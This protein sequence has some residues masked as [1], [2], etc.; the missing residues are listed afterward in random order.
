MSASFWTN[1]KFELTSRKKFISSYLYFAL[2]ATLAYLLV[3]GMGGAM[4][5]VNVSFGL[6]Q[7]VLVNSP[8]AI[9]LL[10]S[11]MSLFGVL[12]ISPVFGRSV[13]KDYDAK[14]DQIVFATPAH[15]TGFYLGRFVGATVFCL[16]AFFGLVVGYYLGSVSPWVQKSLFTANRLSFYLWP[17]FVSVL[18]NIMIFGSLAFAVAAFTKRM[19][20]V[21][22]TGILSFM[23]YIFAGSF[24]GD[25]EKKTLASLV[26]PF[27]INAIS[28]LTEYWSVAERNSRLIPIQGIFLANR[29]LWLGVALTL[30]AAA[31]Y[32][33]QRRSPKAKQKAETLKAPDESRAPMPE[34]KSIQAAARA[35]LD[36]SPRA[37]FSLFLSQLKFETKSA[38]KNIYFVCLTFAGILYVFIAAGQHGLIYGTETY[39]VTYSMLELIAGSFNIFFII[40]ILFYTGELIW[41]DRQSRMNQLIDAM[42]TP[43]WLSSAAKFGAMQVLI[44]CTLAILAVCNMLVQASKG[45][46]HFELGQVFQTLYLQEY[47]SLFALSGLAFFI[48]TL[49]NNKYLG[50]GVFVLYL[51]AKIVMSN[52]GFDHQLYQIASVPTAKYSDM[53]GFGPFLGRVHALQLYW[54]FGVGLMLTAVYLFWVRGTETAGRERWALAKERFTPRARTVAALLFLGFLLQGGYIF[55]NTNVLNEYHMEK[56]EERRSAEYEKTYKAKWDEAPSLKVTAVK[57]QVD[58]FPS[59]LWLKARMVYTLENKTGAPVSDIFLNLPLHKKYFTF[60]FDH[61]AKL[62]TDDDVHDVQIYTFAKPVEP[63]EKVIFT[64]DTD[65]GYEGFRNSGNPTAIAGN[66]SFF[67]S[68]AYFP[69]IGYS[70]SGELS[71]D[72]T[73]E[74][75]GLK[76]KT[77]NMPEI[78]NEKERQYTYVTGPEGDWIDFEATVSTDPDQIAIAPGYLQKEWREGGRRYFEY[79]MDRK[80][81]NFFAFLSARYEVKRDTFNGINLEIYYNKGHEYDLDTMLA[82]T[83]AGLAYYSETFGPY[84]HKQFRIIE[85]PRYASFAQSFPNTIPFSEAIGFIAK[86]DPKNP[87]DLDY[88]YQVTAHELAHQWWAHQVIGANVQGSTMLVE[89]LAEYSSLLLM[90]KKFGREKMS[91]YLDYERDHYLTGRSSEDKAEEP[92]ALNDGQP[93]LHYNKGALVM[94]ALKEYIGEKELNAAIRKYAD[95]VRYQ[96]PPFTTSLELVDSLKRDLDPKYRGLIDDMLMKITLYDNRILSADVKEENGTFNVRLEV[97]GKKMY[98]S[99]KGEETEAPLDL[100]VPVVL[101]DEQGK[102]LA[103]THYPLKSADNSI[104]ISSKVKPYKVKLDPLGVLID[105]NRDDNQKKL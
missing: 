73:R 86:V 6:S 92:L 12:V 17:F 29:A 1:L 99:E 71:S 53:N 19:S 2:F 4:G 83:K 20:A 52:A 102:V 46:T 40:I 16:F 61:D 44:L 104:L 22:F 74:Q 41:R 89:T 101:E 45:Y 70:R 91:R 55:Y 33:A 79:K 90:E 21:Y 27:G 48:H 39:P 25:L 28:R 14:F 94:Y 7:K 31:I 10:F 88:P 81:L 69:T 35:A 103:E 50:H 76:A 72:K 26:D 97:K 5:G 84:Q 43:L 63:G 82:A 67:N 37:R 11:L 18:P 15:R 75:N 58:I 78:T 36:F 23:G 62:A 47:V 60:T 98:S 9:S 49:T 64:S 32:F 95:K 65:Y 105:A 87:K 100:D 13:C 57:A 34:R 56:T 66:G 3:M 68:S 38:L 42:P 80:I 77:R 96:E 24:T 8:Y 54:F 30:L 85:F 59:K 51:I 93:Y